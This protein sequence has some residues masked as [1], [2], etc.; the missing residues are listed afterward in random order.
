YRLMGHFNTYNLSKG[1]DSQLVQGLLKNNLI[2]IPSDNKNARICVEE[3]VVNKTVEITTNF[4]NVSD[5]DKSDHVLK[6][7]IV[8]EIESA[9]IILFLDKKL[10]LFN[11]SKKIGAQKLVTNIESIKYAKG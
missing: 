8:E 1:T 5:F 2:E 4:Y 7:K 3:A 6:R 9:L 11:D 10:R